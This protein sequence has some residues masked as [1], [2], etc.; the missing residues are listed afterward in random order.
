MKW[1][2]W[3]LLILVLGS[4]LAML[5]LL[6]GT[7][8]CRL[9]VLTYPDGEALAHDYDL[10]GRPSHLESQAPQQGLLVRFDHFDTRAGGF[11]FVAGTTLQK[12]TEVVQQRDDLQEKYDTDIK[13]RDHQLASLN[14]ELEIPTPKSLMEDVLAG[15][16]ESRPI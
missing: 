1:W 3:L 12:H 8:V 6:A 7:V 2:I 15:R 13:L 5:V 14:Q 10:G 9:A 11:I 16:V 4:L